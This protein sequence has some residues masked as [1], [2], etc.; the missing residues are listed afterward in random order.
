MDAFFDPARAIAIVATV[1]TQTSG[2]PFP[3]SRL[4]RSCLLDALE[5]GEQIP[6]FRREVRMRPWGGSESLAATDVCAGR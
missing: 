2:R 3:A 1:T 6:V 5:L 4:E